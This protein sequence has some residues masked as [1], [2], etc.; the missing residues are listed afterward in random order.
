MYY[1]GLDFIG[2]S[3]VQSPHVHV[4]AC[5]SRHQYL[6]EI[7]STRLQGEVFLSVQKGVAIGGEARYCRVLL[8]QQTMKICC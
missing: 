3:A 8:V 2:P 5:I 6:L 1:Q 7:V 4:T